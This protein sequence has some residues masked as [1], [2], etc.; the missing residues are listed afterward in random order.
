M[1]TTTMPRRRQAQNAMTHSGRFSEK[2]RTASPL[3]S[4]A[5][6]RREANAVIGNLGEPE[7]YRAAADGQDGYVHTAYDGTSGRGAAVDRTVIEVLLA[8]ARRPRTAE[9][10]A[11]ARRFI[12]YTSPIWVLGRTAE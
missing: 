7:S 12:I 2:N 8:A 3:R 11:P 1:G 6:W 5:A 10:T 9:A 4:P